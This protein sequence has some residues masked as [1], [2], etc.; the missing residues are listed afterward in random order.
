[1]YVNLIGH[2]KQRTQTHILRRIWAALQ[3]PQLRDEFSVEASG[4]NQG[5]FSHGFLHVLSVIK[6]CWFFFP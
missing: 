2:Q 3:I 4:L 1:M 6:S 5:K